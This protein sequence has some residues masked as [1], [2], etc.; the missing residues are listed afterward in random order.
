MLK[1]A[2]LLQKIIGWYETLE[3][4]KRKKITIV[5]GSAL[6]FIIS[7]ILVISTSDD[8]SK[9]FTQKP[10]KIEYSLFNGK[11][12]RDVSID[13]MSGKIKKLTD[14]FSEI[15]ITFQRQDQ[16]IK[17][18]NDL[19]NKKTEEL[20]IRAE[21]LAQ[22]TMELAHQVNETQDTLKNQVVLPEVPMD[23][24]DNKTRSRNNTSGPQKNNPQN[25][26]LSQPPVITEN[27]TAPVNNGLKIRI[28]TS[29]GENTKNAGNDTGATN[30]KPEN[31]KKIAEVVNIKNASGKNVPDMFLPAGSI[32]SGTLITGLDAPTSNQSK[33]DPFPAL[34][35]VKHEAI[36]PNRYRMDI[37]ECFLIASGYGDL[38]SERAY[39]RAERMSCVK[40]DGTV[41]EV[42]IDAYAVGEDGKAGVRGRLVSK[43]GQ[44]I[45]N[46]LLSGFVSGITQAFAPQ[47]VQ[48]IRTNVMSGQ[49]QAFQYPSPEMIGGQGLMGGVKGAAEQIADYYLQ[50]AKNIFPIIEIDAGRKMDFIIVR[51]VMLNNKSRSQVSES[52]QNT[53]YQGGS[54]NFSTSGNNQDQSRYSGFNTGNNFKNMISG[55]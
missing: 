19:I 16:K 11:S 13:A 5:G 50:M 38:S 43:N 20:N 8:N 30:T 47:R 40:T 33:E 28:V 34:L 17:D 54:R 24:K 14:D 31:K 15:R 41:I 7:A 37:R 4:S 48:S 39:M 55:R 36:L 35:R 12:P 42:A 32:M 46:A 2:P 26:L 10:R 25:E 6:L 53:S 9:R 45:G 18:A 3:P 44:I 52:T 22:Q 23:M 29:S 21:K 49:A 51:G 1:N 27:S